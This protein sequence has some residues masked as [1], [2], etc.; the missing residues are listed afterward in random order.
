MVGWFRVTSVGRFSVQVGFPLTGKGT[1]SKI[2]PN[3][4]SGHGSRVGT[5]SVLVSGWYGL[6]TLCGAVHG[7]VNIR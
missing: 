6:S 4:N 2:E 1:V 3:T 5:S 7:A